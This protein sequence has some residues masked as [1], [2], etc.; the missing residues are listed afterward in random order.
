MAWEQMG[1]SSQEAVFGSQ[2][3]AFR[4]TCYCFLPLFV[5][6]DRRAQRAFCIQTAFFFFSKRFFLLRG[7][8][9]WHRR[10]C[11]MQL[12]NT[13]ISYFIVRMSLKY[14]SVAR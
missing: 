8:L 2:F 13:L 1:P 11:S 7:L 12:S 6:F 5:M 9:V 4:S 10:V 3:C 14:W